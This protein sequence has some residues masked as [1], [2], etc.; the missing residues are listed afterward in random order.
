MLAI[1]YKLISGIVVNSRK[2]SITTSV[3]LNSSVFFFPIFFFFRFLIFFP[4]GK[5]RK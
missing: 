2:T 4:M 5:R 1:I 3:H